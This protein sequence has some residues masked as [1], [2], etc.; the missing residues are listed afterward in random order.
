MAAGMDAHA[1][2]E[3]PSK[4]SHS[5]ALLAAAG[6]TLLHLP[7]PARIVL[8]GFQAPFRPAVA[9]RLLLS[10]LTA[11]IERPGIGLRD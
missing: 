11:A 6:S 7:C 3:Y 9:H 4:H 2:P 10:A 1:G 8:G 5:A